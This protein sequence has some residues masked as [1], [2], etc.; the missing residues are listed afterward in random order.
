M[1]FEPRSEKFEGQTLEGMGDIFTIRFL[2]SILRDQAVKTAVIFLHIETM[3]SYFE[4]PRILSGLMGEWTHLPTTNQNI[5]LFIFSADNYEQLADISLRLPV[6]ELRTMILQRTENGGVHALLPIGSPDYQEITRLLNCVRRS[7]GLQMEQ[8]KFEKICRWMTAE[9]LNA[10]QWLIRLSSIPTLGLSTFQ[11]QGWLSAH[12]NRDRTAME[13]LESLI[14]LSPIKQRIREWTAWLTVVQ[15]QVPASAIKSPTIHMVF[16]G[17]P[18]TGKTTLARLMGEIL[19][20]IGLLKRGHL[21]E[22]KGGDLIA[23][24][25]GGTAIKTNHAIDRALDGVL[26]LDEA[27]ALSEPERGGFGQEAL[28]T[29]L[30]RLENER[31]RLVV[32]LAGYPS[33]MSRLLD[34]NPGLARRFP[35]ENI[36]DF[37]DYSPEELWDILLLFLKERNLRLAEGVELKGKGL[38]RKLYL[39]RDEFFGNAGEMRNLV[40]GLERRR[41]VRIQA[42]RLPLDA[43]VEIQDIPEKY[44]D[45]QVEEKPSVEVILEKLDCLVGVEPVKQHLRNLINRLFYEQTRREADPAYSASMGFHHM[46]FVGNPGTGKTTV[47]RLVGE[48]YRSIGLLRKGHC[49]EVSRSD[50]VAGYVGQTALKTKEKVR[51]A[52]DGVLFI[53]EAYSL[54]RISE[55]D[56]GREAIDTLVKSMELY[57]SRL[58]VI[59]AGYPDPM[60]SFL[61]SNPGLRSRFPTILQFPDFSIS[62]LGE[63]LGRLARRETYILPEQVLAEAQNYLEQSQDLAASFGNARSVQELYEHM[64]THL[65]SRIMSGT[66]LNQAG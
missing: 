9:G 46:V 43:P 33:K 27:Y 49:V 37:P 45:I 13:E 1:L 30:A 31:E 61:S 41:A 34:S 19:H 21:I 44:A 17:N 62:E 7:H 64:K 60:D 65:A 8:D 14:G 22:V 11:Q 23:D 15:A 25:V 52:L 48:I 35:K 26:F 5:C 6:P 29:L 36:F 2:N 42:S 53:D 66:P 54:S 10:R 55:N 24:H 50:L 47:A 18:G 32:I 12:R 56:F 38:I 59:A 40:E 28:E 58:I 63:I 3:L 4:N 16:L 57:R 20:E 51:E 39:Q